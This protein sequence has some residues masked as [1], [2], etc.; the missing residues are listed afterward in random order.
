MRSRKAQGRAQ[1][2]RSIW[3]NLDDELVKMVT[4][5]DRIA[6]EQRRQALLEVAGGPDNFR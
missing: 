3:A 4:R 6:L 5:I 2:F 1:P